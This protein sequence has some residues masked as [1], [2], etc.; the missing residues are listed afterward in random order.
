MCGERK[1]E[2]EVVGRET[3][4]LASARSLSNWELARPKLPFC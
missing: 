4:T 1:G 2:V 3:G